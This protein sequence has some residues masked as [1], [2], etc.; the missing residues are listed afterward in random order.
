MSIEVEMDGDKQK[1]REERESKQ[2]VSGCLEMRC[3]VY[4]CV[5]IIYRW[6]R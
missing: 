6:R 5:V 3:D 1:G 2:N 4:G